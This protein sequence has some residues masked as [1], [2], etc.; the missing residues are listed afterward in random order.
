VI[1]LC[2]GRIHVQPS[3]RVASAFAFND[4]FHPRSDLHSTLFLQHSLS[5]FLVL[6][7]CRTACNFIFTLREN[8]FFFLFNSFGNF[9]L[10]FLCNPSLDKLSKALVA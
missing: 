5:G 1:I 8:L 3:F 10:G 2:C 9:F 6:F 7:L 4:S